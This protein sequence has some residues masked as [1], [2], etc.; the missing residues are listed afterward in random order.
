MPPYWTHVCLAFAAMFA[1]IAVVFL[2]VGSC[3]YAAQHKICIK[4]VT[5]WD[6]FMPPKRLPYLIFGVLVVGFVFPL[7]F[8]NAP[9]Q[10]VTDAPAPCSAGNNNT[11]LGE[12]PCH[13]GD[14]NTFVRDADP[15]GNVIHNRGSEAIG[16]DA[17]AGQGG[18]AIGA[19]AN[20]GGGPSIGSISGNSGI[21]Q[22]NQ[23]GPNIV[24]QVPKPKL[25]TISESDTPGADG[26][27]TLTR[28]VEMNAPYG[29]GLTMSVRA[30]GLVMA[31]IGG[32]RQVQIPGNTLTISGAGLLQNVIEMQ[33]FWSG[34]LLNPSGRIEINVVI[35]GSAKPEISLEFQ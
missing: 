19:G 25:K 34:T 15:S 30:K 8:N 32:I 28:I 13:L 6:Q 29:G 24:N 20:A 3:R 23:F 27:R 4:I 9:G 33:G 26:T 18:T 1:L 10:N 21:I 22:Q 14:G 17:R 5:T 16:K 2:A 12:V 11:V 7:A 31:S 35:K